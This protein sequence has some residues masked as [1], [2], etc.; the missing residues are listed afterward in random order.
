MSWFANK[1]KKAI[2][3]FKDYF[4]AEEEM[5][6]LANSI[7]KNK[8]DSSNIIRCIALGDRFFWLPQ[9]IE[10]VDCSNTSEI[11]F[12]TISYLVEL[13]GLEEITKEEKEIR[14]KKFKEENKDGNE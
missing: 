14:I 7:G 5:Y 12:K 3:Y 4:E 11:A 10:D 8:N 1:F 9:P 6:K 2:Q 13:C